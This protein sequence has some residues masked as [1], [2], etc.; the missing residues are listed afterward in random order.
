MS[1]KKWILAVRT[2]M[3]VLAGGVLA[4]PM[5]A[6]ADVGS[7]TMDSLDSQL[8]SLNLP[9]NELPAQVSAEKLYAVQSRFVP[10]DGRSELTMGGGNNFTPDSFINSGQFNLGY[11]YHLNEK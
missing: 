7:S 4:A 11:Q 9:S 10:V 2:S 8:K 3:I 1:S 5:G 6:G